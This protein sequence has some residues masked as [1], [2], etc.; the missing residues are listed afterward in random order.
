MKASIYVIVFGII[1]LIVI[2]AALSTLTF[3]KNLN[4]QNVSLAS[5]PYNAPAPAIQGIAAWINSPPLNLTQLRGKVVLIDFWTYSCI[6]CIRTIPYLNTWYNAYGNNGLVI[7]GVSTPEFEFEHNLTN[8]ENAVKKFGIEYPVALDNNYSTWDAYGNEYWPADY[9]IDKNGNVRY[10]ALGE[11]NYNTTLKVIQELLE[12]AGYN[13]STNVT[14]PQSVVNFSGIGTPE[15]YMGWARARQ[16]L[17]NSQGFVPNELV[18]YTLQNISAE[19]YAYLSGEWYNAN[20]SMI[21]ESN[22]SDLFLIYRAKSLNVVAASDNGTSDIKVY[23]DGN[24]LGQQDLGADV[25]LVNGSAVAQVNQSR[26]YNLVDAPAYGWH[27]I[28]ISA[29]KGFR[30]YTFTFG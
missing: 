4:Q 23:L 13:I 17:G 2:A 10:V 11:G 26:L 6:N 7:I 1:A 19:N 15:I 16:A 14:N 22:N 9:L 20:D 12:N 29:S 28:E 18:N 5:L 24:V 3:N 27:E 25:R 30:I 8:V 21:A